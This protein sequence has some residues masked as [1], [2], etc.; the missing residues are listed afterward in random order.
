ML[1]S[2]RS[3]WAI[4]TSSVLPTNNLAVI[5]TTLAPDEQRTD[6]GLHYIPLHSSVKKL[7]EMHP[8]RPEQWRKFLFPRMSSFD[9]AYFE[10]LVALD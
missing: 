2:G 9:P 5:R 8:E 1:G 3:H 4:V 6:F 10:N 7:K